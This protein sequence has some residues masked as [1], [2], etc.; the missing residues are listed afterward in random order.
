MGTG[1]KT[2]AYITSMADGIAV[3]AAEKARG[4]ILTKNP[5][6]SLS[7]PTQELAHFAQT[8]GTLPIIFNKPD[9]YTTCHMTSL[10]LSFLR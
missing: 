6:S 7:T 4:P 3:E 2:S 5:E 8:A 9:L 10:G 1:V